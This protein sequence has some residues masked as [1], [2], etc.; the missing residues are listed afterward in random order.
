MVLEDNKDPDNIC[1]SIKALNILKVIIHN[2]D[3]D[4]NDYKFIFVGYRQDNIR[5]ILLKLGLGNKLSQE[6]HNELENVIPYYDAKFGDL[7][8]YKVFFVYKYLEENLAIMHLKTILYEI[9][10]QYLT[11]DNLEYSIS[12]FQP[13]KMLIYKYSRSID[14]YFSGKYYIR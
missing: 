2:F 11:D 8:N 6:E 10:K 12:E 13:Y 5:K 7:N 4:N 3:K 14:L 1:N 9:I